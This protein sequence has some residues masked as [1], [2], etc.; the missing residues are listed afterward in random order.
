M[1][2]PMRIRAQLHGDVTAITA[3]ISHPMETGLR[4][5][6]DKVVPAHF[7]RML[8][9]DVGGKRVIESHLNMAVSTNP[10]LNFKAKGA[11]VGDKVE[12]NWEDNL[13]EKGFGESVVSVPE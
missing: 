13:G 12:I 6:G 11:K 8:T 5:E 4:K 9:V 7:I 1:P 10:V 2:Y 3:I